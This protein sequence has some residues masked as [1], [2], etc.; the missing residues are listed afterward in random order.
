MGYEVGWCRGDGIAQGAFEIRAAAPLTRRGF[1]AGGLLFGADGAHGAGKGQHAHKVPSARLL[2]AT[3]PLG[4]LV[5]I[6]RGEARIR[7]VYE[8]SLKDFV[9]LSLQAGYRYNYRFDVDRLTD[10][11]EIYRAFGLLRDDPYAQINS[12]GNPF[13][14]NVSLNLVSP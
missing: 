10:G 12:L 6:R 4:Q 7:A 2:D 14:F 9:W 13:Y 8:F 1:Q 5:E 11:D 3:N